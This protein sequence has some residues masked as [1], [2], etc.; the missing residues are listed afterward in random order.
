MVKF[1]G[2]LASVAAAIGAV[3]AGNGGTS[4]PAVTTASTV[5][6]VVTAVPS[7]T[8]VAPSPTAA[9]TVEN[10]C[11]LADFE[12]ATADFIAMQ[13]LVNIVKTSPAVLKQYVSDPLVIQNQTLATQNISFLGVTFAAT[14]TINF[15]NASGI[16]TIS[17]L[18]VNVTGTN[19]LDLGT[20]FT[21]TIALQATLTVEVAQLDQKW[22]SI[23]WVDLL[24]PIKCRPQ[25]VTVDVAL[26]VSKP[27]V[28]TNIEANL[29]ECAPGVATSVCQNLT[30]TS[31][32]TGALSGDIA[33]LTKAIY[34]NFKDAKVNK[35][36]MGWD[37]ITNLDFAVHN[38]GAFTTQIINGL[39]DFTATEL[40]KKS[41]YYQTFL[42]I[43][44][45]LLLSLL[46]KIIDMQL[47]PQFGAT[48]L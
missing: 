3:S 13:N 23:C 29:Y 16:M 44:Q 30:M 40:N 26:A 48:C 19:S 15:L 41:H 31:I 25:V 7:V 6:P 24:H 5:A 38:T 9:P 8:T 42:E 32:M 22:Y 37:L 27:E 17:P 10:T 11:V 21:G 35:L 2:L 34:K 18:P 36:S 39:V 33:S 45:K 46:N 14:P 20:G 43:S 1:L 47:E 4:A 28:L 12:T